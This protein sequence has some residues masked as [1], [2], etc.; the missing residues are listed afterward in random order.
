MGSKRIFCA[1]ILL[2]GTLMIVPSMMTA[3]SST[4]IPFN[5]ESTERQRVDRLQFLL[6]WQAAREAS[7]NA[8]PGLAINYF[9][10]IQ[11][12]VPV[13]KSVR[14]PF[15]RDFLRAL[16]AGGQFSEAE[17]IIDDLVSSGSFTNEVQLWQA[18]IAFQQEDTDRLNRIFNQINRTELPAEIVSWYDLLQGYRYEERGRNEQARQSFER[19][20]AAAPNRRVTA[21]FEAILLRTEILLGE[22]SG[23]RRDRIEESLTQNATSRMDS[24]LAREYAII[25]DKLGQTREALEFLS[26]QLR[27]TPF[28]S[29]GERESLLLVV[30]EIAPAD[31][32]E[33]FSA[34]EEIVLRGNEKRILQTALQNLFGQ[35]INDQSYL[36]LQEF[37]SK[38]LSER[39]DHPLVDEILFF[40]ATAA[41]RD[42][43]IQLAEQD[44]RKIIDAFPASPAILDAKKIIAETAWRSQPPRYRTAAS[45]Y[46]EL[47]D[48]M[49]NPEEQ[50]RYSIWAADAFFLASDFDGAA[51][52]YSEVLN[53]QQEYLVVPRAWIIQQLALSEIKRNNAPGAI[54]ALNFATSDGTLQPAD[55]WELE[56]Q[57]SRLLI[58]QGMSGNALE[59]LNSLL[60]EEL[61]AET[62][63]KDLLA[64]LLWLRAQLALLS[65]EKDLAS[66]AIA[67][68][69]EKIQAERF[70]EDESL[71]LV[72][73][74]ELES[75]GLLMKGQLQLSLNNLE[76]ATTIFDQL[77][78]NFRDSEAAQLS[79]LEESR[80][81]SNLGR[82]VEAQN[83]LVRLAD[84]SPNSRLAPVALYEAAILAEKRGLSATRREA[85]SLLDR[86]ANDYQGNPLV[87][88]ARLRMGSI[89]REL[90]EFGSALAIYDNIL[91]MH[92][93]NARLYLARM[94]RIQSLM[95]LAGNDPVRMEEAIDSL[96]RLSRDDRLPINFLAE[97]NFR[98]VTALTLSLRKEEALKVSWRSVNE[99]LLKR[100]SDLDESGRF[101]M[102][103]TLFAL[104]E[105]EESL[106][107]P[108]GAERAYGYF[109]EFQ[110]PGTQ[111]A[112]SRLEQ[113]QN[114]IEL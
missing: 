34:K 38:V 94:G 97:A 13:D 50:T 25:L 106:P 49:E 46:L 76:E 72:T 54:E 109:V 28:G 82:S 43:S 107:F 3:T 93:N 61:T 39:P 40:R 91:Q 99:L 47:R 41:L 96:E 89:L 27:L 31:S 9:R 85:L 11:E 44:A 58:R 53:R 45:L 74:R 88:S 30:A 36:E 21:Y 64:R 17:R 73:R 114:S 77:R 14:L 100:S 19:G 59:R 75:R 42:G 7:A 87:F 52:L 10:L 86:L 105:M 37:L 108:N 102:A 95:A 48:S 81:L 56:W 98:L 16:I 18:W 60:S 65:G 1:Y 111:L 69:L 84:T 103:R 80:K 4:P 20:L 29:Q 8:L 15:Q 83:L 32:L 70:T 101:W 57:L 26:N 6:D 24:H 63:N 113:L 2:L 35:R 110:L 55:R 71:E 92:P 22:F 68:Y 104:A 112:Q 90:G 23:N 67:L 78:Q 33:A 5:Q 66:E 79:F 51:D 62:E 12:S